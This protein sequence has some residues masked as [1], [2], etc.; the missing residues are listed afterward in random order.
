[1]L[2]QNMGEKVLKKKNYQ[3][4][5]KPCLLRNNNK[6]KIDPKGNEASTCK[7]KERLI[8]DYEKE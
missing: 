3:S 2:F 7:G 6:Q 4:P 8:D 5:E 1:M